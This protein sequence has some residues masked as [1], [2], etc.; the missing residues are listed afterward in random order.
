MQQLV[1]R[2]KYYKKPDKEILHKRYSNL[3]HCSKECREAQHKTCVFQFVH[4]CQQKTTKQDACNIKSKLNCEMQA[5]EQ[6]GK[7]CYN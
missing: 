3:L 4:M 2:Y 6:M 5:D 7:P 1:V